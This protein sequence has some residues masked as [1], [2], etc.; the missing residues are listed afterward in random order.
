MKSLL[1]KEFRENAK[2]AAFPLLL[3][4][5]IFAVYGPRPCMNGEF[6]VLVSVVAALFGG[7]L[8]FLQVASESQGDRRAL[9]LHRPMSASRI[10][11]AKAIA[12]AGIYL[13]ALGFPFAVNAIWTALP[14]HVAEPFRWP[15]VIP[16]LADI[17]SGIVYYFAGM[18]M[19]ERQ[20]RWYGSRCLGFPAAFLSSLLVWNVPE[21]W[22]AIVTILICGG[23]AAV[24]AW[25]SFVTGGAYKPQPLIAKGALAITFLAGLTVLSV[26][27][28]FMLGMML[29]DG[30]VRYYHMDRGGR[31]LVVHHLSNR[32]MRV[33]DLEDRDLPDFQPK[34]LASN[35]AMSEMMAPL[36]GGATFRWRSYR[37]QGAMCVPYVNETTPRGERWFFC[38]RPGSACGLRFPQAADRQ[39]RARWVRTGRRADYGAVPGQTVFSG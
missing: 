17:L 36:T 6:L 38:C 30:D 22:Q 5:G 2:W 14:G 9:L 21:F 23:L 29:V 16:W 26:E 18:L 37:M 33:T 28:K 8:G 13:A 15:V 20:G 7:V 3:F 25:G 32:E 27:G 39:H 34:H 31:L 19:A 4:C 24:S 10:F 35:E 1:W 11:M 12:G